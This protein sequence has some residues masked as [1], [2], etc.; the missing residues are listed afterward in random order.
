[1]VALLVL[2]PLVA[3]LAQF[4]RPQP[5]GSLT[6]NVTNPAHTALARKIAASAAV[7]LKNSGNVLPVCVCIGAAAVA[8]TWWGASCCC[9]QVSASVKRI[10]VIGVAAAGAAV[11]GGHG[12]GAV[13]P[14]YAVSPL[15]VG[16]R[17]ARRCAR[18]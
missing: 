3:A 9:F 14:L 15:E 16:W 4:D 13:T 1:M 12:S 18:V 8:L 11:F 7:L 2:D 5:T 10:A 6:N 17:R